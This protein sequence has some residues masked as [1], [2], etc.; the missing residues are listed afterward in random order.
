MSRPI[1][2][3]VSDFKRRQSLEETLTP[4]ENVKR[5]AGE[6][7]FQSDMEFDGNSI[8]QMN[9]DFILVWANFKSKRYKE[10]LVYSDEILS[11]PFYL[12]IKKNINA[13]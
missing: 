10:A 5:K 6:V 8:T 11:L 13:N 9:K 1:T 4:S 7:P 12:K 2:F 3:N